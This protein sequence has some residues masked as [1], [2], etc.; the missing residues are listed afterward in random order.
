MR[1]AQLCI[2]LGLTCLLIAP[3]SAQTGFVF[4]SRNLIVPNPNNPGTDYT[5]IHHAGNDQASHDALAYDA[6]LGYGFEVIDPGNTGRNGSAQYGPFDNSPNNRNAFAD[7][8]PDELY[9]SFIG[10][11]NYTN[12][13]DEA[14]IGDGSTPCAP[15]IPAEGGIFRVDVPNGLY[16]FV[17]V[18]GDADNVHAHRVLVENGGSGGVDNVGANHVVLVGN[19]DQAQFTTGQTNPNEL[20]EGVF[21][22]VGFDNVLPPEP[23]GPD[24]FPVFADYD[25]S[26][27]LTD[28]GPN[29]P[30]LE[31]TEGYLRL[32]LLQG[33]S[34]D[35]PGGP[36][37][38]N[39]TDIVLFEAHLVPEPSSALLVLF[40]MLGIAASRRRRR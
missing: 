9:D 35:G 2:A 40:G 13:C 20:G 8:L 1:H 11:K 23:L 34:N 5:M 26:G 22:R 12:T 10:F 21:A 16:R 32:H 36:R 30:T 7:T 3:A 28:A 15:T 14:V 27:N 39:G 37:D 18:F 6:G 38:A 31:V 19:H 4:G 17:G 33:N 24:V 25:E 29:S